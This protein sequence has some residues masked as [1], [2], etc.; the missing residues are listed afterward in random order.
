MRWLGVTKVSPLVAALLVVKHWSHPTTSCV[1]YSVSPRHT[2]QY[3]FIV[4]VHHGSVSIHYQQ[5]FFR[6]ENFRKSLFPDCVRKWNS[7]ESDLRKEC[8]HN[9]FR[10]KT[11]SN[12]HCSNLYYVGLRKTNIIHA[13]LR[14][15]CSNLNAHLHSLPSFF[16][17]AY[18]TL[19]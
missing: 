12:V 4:I 9:L 2:V 11:T 8:S 18:F 7:L 6:T 3:S 15:N 16:I 1:I 10:S 14:M 5:A 13:E 19:F 17:R